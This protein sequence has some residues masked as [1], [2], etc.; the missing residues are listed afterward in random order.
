MSTGGRQQAGAGRAPPTLRA[1]L[2]LKRAIGNGRVSSSV[3]SHARR[4]G[5]TAATSERDREIAS[6]M[7]RRIAG[8]GR[9]R[10]CVARDGAQDRRWEEAEGPA[11]AIMPSAWAFVGGAGDGNRTRTVSL[12]GA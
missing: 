3:V 4:A 8:E 11:V 9:R 2:I 5:L 6:A 12:E 10:G 1:A 7:D